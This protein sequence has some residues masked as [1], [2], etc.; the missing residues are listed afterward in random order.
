MAH[1][2]AR[3]FLTLLILVLPI[4]FAGSMDSAAGDDGRQPMPQPKTRLGM[5]LSGPADWNTE[6]PFVDVFRLSRRWVSQKEGT[7]GVLRRQPARLPEIPGNH[8][9]GGKTG[10]NGER[11]AVSVFGQPLNWQA[12]AV[13]NR[14]SGRRHRLL[15]YGPG[16]FGLEQQPDFTEHRG[17]PLIQ[18]VESGQKLLV[19][20]V[21]VEN[22]LQV[23]Q[24]DKRWFSH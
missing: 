7:Y 2:H 8:A 15:G 24:V 13:A 18:A 17:N 12:R 6:L 21:E 9:M 11:A 19:P 16:R 23:V 3:L 14:S 20:P 5:N 22:G 4:A 10:P 1:V